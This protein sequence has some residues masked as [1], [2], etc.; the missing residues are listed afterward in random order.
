MV[1][2]NGND[3][4]AGGAGRDMILAGSGDDLA[5]GGGDLVC[6]PLSETGEYFLARRACGN[7]V[8]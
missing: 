3:A 8:S 2:G 5:D 7:G 6:D 1:G 4:I